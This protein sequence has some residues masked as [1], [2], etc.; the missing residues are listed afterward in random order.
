MIR[1]HGAIRLLLGGL[2]AAGLAGCPEPA[3][4]DDEYGNLRRELRPTLENTPIPSPSPRPERL[5]RAYPLNSAS[6]LIERDQLKFDPEVSADGAGSLRIDVDTPTTVG[7]FETGPL[8][9]DDATLEYRALV[10]IDQASGPAVLEMWVEIGDKKD[11]LT[12]R[13]IEPT[14]N[15]QDWIAVT[16]PFELQKGEY[17]DN[18]RLALVIEGEARLWIDD[19]QLVA[20]PH[21]TA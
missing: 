12:R 4:R 19:I 14:G 1:P 17:P 21:A 16:A 10:R 8:E 11:L 2:I 7:L 18:V 9:V 20:V 6:E 3:P 5:I 13:L 15:P